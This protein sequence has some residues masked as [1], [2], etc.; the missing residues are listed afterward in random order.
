MF[1][2]SHET[3][4]CF[5]LNLNSFSY[6]ILKL[7]IQ[8]SWLPWSVRGRFTLR[9]KETTIFPLFAHLILSNVC[10]YRL[11]SGV[12]S[13]L[14]WWWQCPR[15]KDDRNREGETEGVR[16]NKGNS[17]SHCKIV[18]NI[19]IILRHKVR[20]VA[21]SLLAAPCSFYEH[22]IVI[23]PAFLSVLAGQFSWFTF[24]LLDWTQ[25]LSSDVQFNL[26]NSI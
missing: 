3:F 19:S 4:Q 21:N 17:S 13:N 6:P 20:I 11:V 18:S 24:M 25:L 15:D 22:L 16:L 5:P 7:K 8:R 1:V 23:A 9:K 26:M 10:S 14:D 12:G 2:L